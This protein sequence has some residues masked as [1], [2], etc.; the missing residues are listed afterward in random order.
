MEKY[1]A[2]KLI[3]KHRRHW[4]LQESDAVIARRGQRTYLTAGLTFVG[5]AMIDLLSD[6]HPTYRILF[7]SII[8]SGGA[9]F[10]WQSYR[11]ARARK[12]LTDAETDSH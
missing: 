12:L 8:F 5:I 7:P 3:E 11:F 6:S 4:H 2:T 1:A 10:C 9:L